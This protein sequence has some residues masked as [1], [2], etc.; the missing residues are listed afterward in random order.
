MHPQAPRDRLP[1][2]AACPQADHGV[3]NFYSSKK[4]GYR[5]KKRNKLTCGNPYK[6]KMAKRKREQY[7]NAG[8]NWLLFFVFLH[9]CLLC[10]FVANIITLYSGVDRGLNDVGDG[11]KSY[12]H[13]MGTDGSSI[14]T[15]IH[16]GCYRDEGLDDR[17]VDQ[18]TPP[19]THAMSNNE[20]CCGDTDET[21][22]FATSGLF[23]GFELEKNDLNELADGLL[24][25]EQ[26]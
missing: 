21:Y 3:Y 8:F 22:V 1:G 14:R 11:E 5:R 15:P 24:V 12:H 19:Y 16:R 17:E 2:D 6:R 26:A 4:T 7:G 10:F 25:N 9:G 20:H 18:R 23:A 13:D